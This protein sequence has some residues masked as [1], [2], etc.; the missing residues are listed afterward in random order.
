[1]FWN[2]QSVTL[3]MNVT[4]INCYKPNSR[5]LDIYL[6][7]GRRWVK[8]RGRESEV[9][10]CAP[11]PHYCQA[12]FT[13]HGILFLNTQALAYTTIS[14]HVR[15]RTYKSPVAKQQVQDILG[16]L[17]CIPARWRLSSI[18]SFSAKIGRWLSD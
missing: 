1:M 14:S 18:W 17:S 12:K 2:M 11:L 6:A 8:T 3:K 9:D 7:S 4:I 15:L 5:L 10:V 13:A 16:C